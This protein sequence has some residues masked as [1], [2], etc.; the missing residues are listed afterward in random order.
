MYPPPKFKVIFP[1]QK[2]WDL[3]KP[4]RTPGTLAL[5]KFVSCA[6]DP[7]YRPV[8]HLKSVH[9]RPMQFSSEDGLT[10][11]K[12]VE[13]DD[14]TEMYNSH[15]SSNPPGRPSV[16]TCSRPFPWGLAPPW[17]SSDP[18]EVLGPYVVATVLV[19]LQ[20][21]RSLG[22]RTVTG[23]DAF[24]ILAVCVHLEMSFLFRFQCQSAPSS[25]PESDLSPLPDSSRGDP[26]ERGHWAG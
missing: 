15:Y 13:Q 8:T 2:S 23:L 16:F 21:P 22:I 24:A 7:S 5:V 6:D 26:L 4:A 18:E 19:M 1:E 3:E 10:Q 9:L 14:R 12:E 25:Q 20:V 11:S 17:T